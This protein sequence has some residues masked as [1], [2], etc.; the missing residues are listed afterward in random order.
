[1]RGHSEGRAKLAP[2]PESDGQGQWLVETSPGISE[3]FSCQ[4]DACRA[5]AIAAGHTFESDKLSSV[6]G[7]W[8]SEI[9]KACVGK[10]SRYGD[11]QVDLSPLPES[12]LYLLKHEAIGL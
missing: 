1:M 6:K 10:N 3:P 4:V 9:A 12:S 5:A 2:L 11:V 8:V 7:L